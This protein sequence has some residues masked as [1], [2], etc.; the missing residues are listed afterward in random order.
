LATIDTAAQALVDATPNA[1]QVADHLWLLLHRVEAAESLVNVPTG[2]LDA[3][4]HTGSAS[5]TLSI[6]YKLP[7]LQRRA[8]A[9]ATIAN[10]CAE[11]GDMSTAREAA[12]HAYQ[13]AADIRGRGSRAVTLGRVAGALIR[14]GQV[15]HGR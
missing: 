6:A 10:A 5:R 3:L 15:E 12:Q 8:L 11:T 9:L 1:Q 7:G 4:A 14:T 2:V 13:V